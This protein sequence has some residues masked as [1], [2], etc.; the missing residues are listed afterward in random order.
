MP[1]TTIIYLAGWG[2]SGSTLL[3]RTLGE[4]DGWLA[5]GEVRSVWDLG[6]LRN[7]PCGCGE[8]FHV[9]PFWKQVFDRAFG[10]MDMSLARRMVHLAGQLHTWH[11]LLLPQSH[12]DRKM[13]SNLLAYIETLELLYNAIRAVSGARVLIDSSKMPAYGFALGRMAGFDLKLVHLVRDPR[14]C[15]YSWTKRRKHQPFG[16]MKSIGPVKN[17]IQ[18]VQRNRAVRRMWSTDSD[19]YRLVR[20]E[21]FIS[22]PVAT[23]RELARFAGDSDADLSFLESHAVRLGPSHMAAGNP[24]RFD[25]G[26]IA[27]RQDTAWR[28]GL[29]SW[30]EATVRLLSGPWLKSYGYSGA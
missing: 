29:S 10:G 23:I 18:W 4:L 14:A 2:R 8:P 5:I 26:A 25:V 22:T 17:S 19:R 28:G 1:D 13:N 12:L 24:N 30:D 6:V 27:L 20:Y 11:L 21:D 15:T 7:S 3:C 9:C 16:R